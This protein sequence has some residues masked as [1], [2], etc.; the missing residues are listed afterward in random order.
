MSMYNNIDWTQKS[1]KEICQPNSERSPRLLERSLAY[2]R[3]HPDVGP[4]GQLHGNNCPGC[5]GFVK[6]GRDAEPMVIM[7]HG[8][9]NVVPASIGLEPTDQTRHY[10]Q[11]MHLK[12][13]GRKRR[14]DTSS[15]CSKSM[16]H[17][18]LHPRVLE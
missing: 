9:F 4:R 8:S 15:S 5:C 12:F 13:A 3:R 17:G 2:F 14:R 6:V 1:K 18:S 7:L 16:R 10:E 11:W